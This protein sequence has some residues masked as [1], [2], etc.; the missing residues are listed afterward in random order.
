LGQFRGDADGGTAILLPVTDV[1]I[2]EGNSAI[3]DLAVIEVNL[4]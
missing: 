3:G 1:I 2:R 4:P